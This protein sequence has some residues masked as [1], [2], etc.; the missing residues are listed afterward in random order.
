MGSFD[1]CICGVQARCSYAD[2]IH[3]DYNGAARIR[4]LALA[5]LFRCVPGFLSA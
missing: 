4:S 3:V 1:R 2:N 5:L